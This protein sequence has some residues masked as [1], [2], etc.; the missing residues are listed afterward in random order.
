MVE[1]IDEKYIEDV[2]VKYTVRRCTKCCRVI[3][4]PCFDGCM[5]P[6]CPHGFEPCF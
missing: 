2:E 6:K 1:K 3:D 5:W 4:D